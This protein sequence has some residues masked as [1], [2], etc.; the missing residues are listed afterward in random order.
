MARARQRGADVLRRLLR[1]DADPAAD[2]GTTS[3]G[4]ARQWG[5]PFM[6]EG[7]V[8]V[9]DAKRRRRR[10]HGDLGVEP[11][12]QQPRQHPGLDPRCCPASPRRSAARSRC[13]STAAS[14]G[15]ATSSRRWPWAP[16][17]V[18]IE[19]RLSVGPRR[20]RPGRRRERARR[21]PW[22]PRLGP[23]R[24]GQRRSTTCRP[25]TSSSP[26]DFTRTA[27]G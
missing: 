14:A 20:Q 1:V 7:V 10:R 9:D 18:M 13:C 24:P 12:R 17:P 23:A 11:R 19:A 25:P 15:A 6:L 8:R 27:G 26:A 3:P 22:R 16:R 5:G 4:S 2:A 21:A